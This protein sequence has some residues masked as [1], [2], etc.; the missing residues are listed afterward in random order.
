MSELKN[1]TIKELN[2]L[3]EEKRIELSKS[4]MEIKMG[5]SASI[6]SMKNLKSDVARIITEMNV[7]RG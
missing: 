6:H 1:L 5:K 2:L 7:R 3:L 4:R